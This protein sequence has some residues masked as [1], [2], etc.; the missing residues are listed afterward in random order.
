M[1]LKRVLTSL[2]VIVLLLTV[3]LP[4]NASETVQEDQTSPV[5]NGWVS[6]DGKMFYYES[7]KLAVNK[8]INEASGETY[9]TDLN[10]ERIIGLKWIIVDGNSYCISE[11]GRLYKDTWINSSVSNICKVDKTGALMT[12]WITEGSTQYYA[13]KNGS[14]FVD[15]WFMV[16]NV[17]YRADAK[18]KIL[19]NCWVTNN[20]S[21][22]RVDSKGKQLKNSWVTVSNA[23]YRLDSSGK[24]LKNAWV[25]V[26]GSKY[27]VDSNGKLI[28]N[29]WVKDGLYTYRVDSS[30]KQLKNCWVTV[31]KS[32]YR[33]DANGKQLKNCWVTVGNNKYRLDKSG[34]LIKNSWVTIK[35][36]KHRVN[37]KG[38]LYKSKSF[39]VGTKK[40][41][42]NSKGVVSVKLDV[43][44]ILQYPELPTG[45]EITSITQILQYTG[46]KVD[47]IALANEMPKHKNDPHKGFVGSPFKNS[48]WTVYP[49][50]L[51][52]L[53]KKYAG[54]SKIMTKSSIKDL[55][56]QLSKGKPI[57]VWVAKWD[58][59][60]LHCVV[61]TGY[62]NKYFYYND[63]SSNK[64]NAK[65]T[66][67][68][69]YKKWERWGYQAISY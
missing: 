62:D 10:G 16:G 25:T 28:T 37:S 26:S 2:L 68:S 63:C 21:T 44:L 67:D 45:C 4:V 48:G 14:I 49:K 40:Y 8:W 41:T 32:Q 69:F 3:S 31:S 22:Y 50:A 52:K 53:V 24:L 29:T 5:K 38:V 12:G 42:A 33:L 18:G 17:T 43:P 27:R 7:N 34:K 1:L 64:K 51:E 47:K 19:K 11:D 39:T 57:A 9:R 35:G 66:I 54:S 23:K 58:Q 59:W 55:K 20:G 56:N 65:I 61:L 15:T 6:E 60:F 13:Q 30:G 36:I 46:A